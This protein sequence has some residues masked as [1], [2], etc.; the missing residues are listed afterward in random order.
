MQE[1][2]SKGVIL[3]T[4][5]NKLE[6]HVKSL[7]QTIA[8]LARYIGTTHDK[9]KD[10]ELPNDIR[11]LC[12]Q[13]QQ[14][15][16]KTFGV[17]GQKLGQNFT[18]KFALTDFTNS[19]NGLNATGVSEESNSDVDEKMGTNYD[20]TR[21]LSILKTGLSTPNL[22][23]KMPEVNKAAQKA[24]IDDPELLK[25]RQYLSMKK[26]YSCNAGLM[27]P[28]EVEKV[29]DPQ[30]LTNKITSTL[31]AYPLRVLDEDLEYH[32]H[33][34][35][36][37][38]NK[39]I[40]MLKSS[41]LS[42]A[43][44]IGSSISSGGR[45]QLSE[46]LMQNIDSPRSKSSSFFAHSH[47]QIRQEKLQAEQLK[48]DFDENLKR[49]DA[50]LSPNLSF[51]DKSVSSPIS[52]SSF[53]SS[54]FVSSSEVSK[55]LNESTVNT[56]KKDQ[57]DFNGKVSISNTDSGLGTPLS[58]NEKNLIS[59]EGKLQDKHLIQ[60]VVNHPLGCDMDIKFEVQS[61][62]LKS[63]RPLKV[64]PVGTRNSSDNASSRN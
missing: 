5:H 12:Q 11:R 31:K 17:L 51:T 21:K 26:S 30:V 38:T 61:S 48:R 7:E 18:S 8:T 40:E 29:K 47:E 54:S 57:F 23:G 53:L 3:Q 43:S 64:L 15:D 25:K 49:L 56:V 13:V 9:K 44:S 16:K 63:I 1:A 45:S 35:K 41:N 32:E 24:P 6:S 60:D 39:N 33:L 34:D 55:K 59:P 42:D 58:P 37:K 20:K 46:N 27:T 2:V 52:N 4:S 36:P 62:K 22:F 19:T 28:K 50:R 10:S 14:N